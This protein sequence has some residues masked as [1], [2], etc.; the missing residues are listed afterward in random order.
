MRH[1]NI[2]RNSIQA[3]ARLQPRQDSV[4]PSQHSR[5]VAPATVEVQVTVAGLA[6]VRAEQCRPAPLVSVRAAWVQAARD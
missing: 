6:L 1:F 5:S 2:A 3:L 4:I